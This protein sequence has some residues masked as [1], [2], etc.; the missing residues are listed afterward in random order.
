[1]LRHQGVSRHTVSYSIRFGLA[2][3]LGRFGRTNCLAASMKVDGL[4]EI[5]EAGIGGGGRCCGA[6]WLTLTYLR[7]PTGIALENVF[8]DGDGGEE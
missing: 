5:E 1:M 3:G 6:K 2:C 8:D 4:G 7:L